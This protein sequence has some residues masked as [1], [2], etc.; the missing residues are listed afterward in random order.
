MRIGLHWTQTEQTERVYHINETTNQSLAS[1]GVVYWQHL[2]VHRVVHW[3]TFHNA[4]RCASQ[5]VRLLIRLVVAVISVRVSV[6]LC[7]GLYVCVCLFAYSQQ[8]LLLLLI[9]PLKLAGLLHRYGC[10]FTC[11]CVVLILIQLFQHCA[12]KRMCV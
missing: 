2:A 1:K 12:S 9:F 10:A 8:Q 11:L 5:S 7:A 4:Y 3:P 6:Y